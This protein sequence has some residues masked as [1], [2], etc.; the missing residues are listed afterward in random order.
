MKALVIMLVAMF[1]AGCQLGGSLAVRDATGV[2]RFTQFEGASLV[3]K[4]DLKIAAGKARVFLQN[5]EVSGWFDS[6]QPHCSFEIDSVQHDGVSIQADTFTVSR[7]QGSI[8]RVVSREPIRV[9]SLQLL[10]GMAGGG[11]SQ[12]FYEGY[13]FWLTSANQPQV[14]RMSCFGVYAQPYELYPPTVE[15]IRQVLGSIAEIRQ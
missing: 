2:D 15:E 3:L 7:V 9:A 11:G 8:Q 13:H 5:G 10:A 4:Q 14:R 1:L 6:Y 12:S